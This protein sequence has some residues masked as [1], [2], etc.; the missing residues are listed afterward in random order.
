[1]CVKNGI[2]YDADITMLNAPV[3]MVVKVE[4]VLN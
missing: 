1:L 3:N 4:K 2:V